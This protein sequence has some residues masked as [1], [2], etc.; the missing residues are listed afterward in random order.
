MT[1]TLADNEKA[2]A[3]AELERHGWEYL[4]DRDAVRRTFS[5]AD[6]P[7]AMAWMNAVAELAE[8]LNHHPEWA[9]IYNRVTV[10]LTTHSTKCLTSLDIHLAEGMDNLHKQWLPR[11]KESRWKSS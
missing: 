7:D 5:F 1:D 10:T 4:E 8:T 6:F 9:N 3:L 2:V 11:L